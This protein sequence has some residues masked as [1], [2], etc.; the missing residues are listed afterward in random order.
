MSLEKAVFGI[1]QSLFWAPW[2]GDPCSCSVCS[3]D[4][5]FVFLWQALQQKVLMSGN[6]YVNACMDVSRHTY[7]L[8][9]MNTYTRL[10]QD[11]L[12]PGL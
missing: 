3:C 11:F 1:S 10:V 2:L 7:T 9:T 12:R 4:P 8:G 6:V 5:D